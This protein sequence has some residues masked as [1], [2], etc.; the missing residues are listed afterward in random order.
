MCV[1]V[2]L[3]HWKGRLAFV[4]RRD[5]FTCCKIVSIPN[6]INGNLSSIALVLVK[7]KMD[8]PASAGLSPLTLK[9]TDSLLPPL[10]SHR[11]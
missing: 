3:V 11:G 1:A 4:E 7:M 8:I 6:V 2:G 9:P 10:R 5:V